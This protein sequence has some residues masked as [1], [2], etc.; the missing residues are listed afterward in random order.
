MAIIKQWI[1]VSVVHNIVIDAY[2]VKKKLENL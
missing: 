1:D 2:Q